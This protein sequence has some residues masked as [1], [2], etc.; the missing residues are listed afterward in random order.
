[1]QLTNN[2]KLTALR[3]QYKVKISHLRYEKGAKKKDKPKGTVF[4]FAAAPLSPL[5]IS[6]KGAITRLKV[7]DKETDKEIITYISKCSLCDTFVKR[8]GIS[9]VVGEAY[10]H[11]IERPNAIDSL[12]VKQ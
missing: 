12:L 6:P 1:M 3:K 11:L 2:Q 4:E 9:R 5:L 8:I 7:L 10:K